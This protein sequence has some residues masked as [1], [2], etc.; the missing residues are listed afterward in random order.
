MM[1]TKI[2]IPRKKIVE[3]SRHWKVTEFSLF[4]SVLRDDF[5][6]DSDVDVLVTFAPDAQISLFDLVQMKLDL[7]K[8]FR[9]PV[10][11][12]EKDALEN[13]F[14]KREILRTAQVI[15]ADE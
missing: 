10:D 14:R 15:Y 11:V 2:R 6:P 1:K 12:I 13:P 4:G 7:E 9:R 5:R 8:I 3:F